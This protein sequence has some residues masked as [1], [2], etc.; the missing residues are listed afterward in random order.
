ML[1]CFIIY[2]RGIIMDEC[3]GIFKR[4]L[5]RLNYLYAKANTK[6]KK[7]RLAFDLIFFEICI[8]ILLMI[9]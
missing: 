1:V 2:N 8:K 6:S 3:K 4:E 9:K 5:G 7:V